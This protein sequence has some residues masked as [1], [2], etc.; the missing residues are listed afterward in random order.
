VKSRDSSVGK[1]TGYW[2]DSRDSFPPRGK[3]F[4]FSIAFTPVLGPTQP[5]IQWVPGAI[6]PGLERLGREAENSPSSSAE[7]KSGGA[8]PPLPHTSSWRSALLVNARSTGIICI[9]HG[10]ELQTKNSYR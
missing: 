10:T 3:V 6:Y 5:P 9:Y 2:L 1:E 8:I 4:L 7:V